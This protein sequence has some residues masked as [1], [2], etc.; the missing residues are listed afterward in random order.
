MLTFGYDIEATGV[1]PLENKLLTIQYRRNSENHVFKL[2][3]YNDSERDLIL[4]FL[5]DWKKIPRQLAQGGDYFVTYNFRLGGGFLL[6][7][8]L[9]N[10]GDD[11]EW[12]KHLWS[13]LFHGPDFIDIEQ[14]LGNRL[15][16]FDQWRTRFGL[17]PSRFK[18]FDIPKLYSSGRYEDILSYVNDELINLEKIYDRLLKEPFYV[19]L[20][21]L[22]RPI[23]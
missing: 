23:V 10:L 17:E 21:K 6:V 16:S 11:E 8:S 5:E 15:T 3:D 12:R 4:T 9:L 13:T 1:D 20:E 18:N 22:R 19:E 2:W 7:R 14:L